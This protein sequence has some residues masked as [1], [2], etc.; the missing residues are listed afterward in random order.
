M[1]QPADANI[2]YIHA[3]K[4]VSYIFPDSLALELSPVVLIAESAGDLS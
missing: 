4:A 1:Q 3:E 2:E